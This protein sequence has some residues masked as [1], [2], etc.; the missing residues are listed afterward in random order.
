MSQNLDANE[1]L[2][3][4]RLIRSEN[5]GPITFYRL[6]ERYGTATQALAHVHDLAKRGGRKKAIKVCSK[7]KALEELESL[8]Q[9]GADMVLQAD[10]QYPPL[11]KHVEDA[12]PVLNVKGHLHLLTKKCVAIVGARNASI[13]GCKF[14]A[15]I[16]QELGQG[17]LMVVSGLARGIDGA[18]HAA[19]L[20]TGTL[21]VLGGGVD[22]IYP[23]ENAHLY[24]EMSE[25]GCI[26]AEPKAGTQP[27]ARHFPRRNRLISGM[28]RAIVVVEASPRSGSLIT[29]RLALEQGREVFAVPG[30]PLDP[31]SKGANSLIRD[32]AHLL[33]EP[34]NIFDVLNQIQN[35]PLQE[36]KKSFFQDVSASEVADDTLTEARGEIVKSLS[37][38]PVLIDE[39][40][41][42]CQM[43]AS[44]VQTVLLELELAGRLERHSGGRVSLII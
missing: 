42:Q 24:K 7:S 30:S 33:E 17:G 29:A 37:P 1:R 11:L 5:V 4:L 2:S 21:G 32:G 3:W 40:I 31:R 23:K 9:I 25:R 12:P 39:I 6:L 19:A 22:V 28:A 41:R 35:A 18:A 36:V 26:I 34:K 15:Q 10:P 44:I 38:T 13:N 27:Q 16:S 20:N 14:A 8:S 43:S